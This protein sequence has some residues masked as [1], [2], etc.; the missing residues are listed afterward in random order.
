M[1]AYVAHVSHAYTMQATN[2]PA[3]VRQRNPMYSPSVFSRLMSE[4][5]Y[6]PIL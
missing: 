2:D 6:V 4:I 1:R 5:W 3:S